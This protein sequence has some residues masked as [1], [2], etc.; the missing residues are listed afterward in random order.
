M[1]IFQ[2]IIEIGL[3]A[4]W[5]YSLYASLNPEATVDWTIERYER[6]MKFYGF[7]ATIKPTK[8]SAVIIRK[9]HLVVLTLLTIYMALVYLY[10]NAF[11]CQLIK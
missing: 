7:K 6:M 11:M 5:A 4:L 1:N 8:R 10:G 2:W 9:G 3:A